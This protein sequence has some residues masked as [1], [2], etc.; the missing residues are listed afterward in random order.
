MPPKT[1]NSLARGLMILESSSHGSFRMSLAE[2]SRV[3]H[4]PKASAYRLLKTLT[5]LNYLKYDERHKEYYLGPKVLSLGFSVVQSLE[6]QEIIR[7]YLQSLSR[8]CAKTVNF[9]VLD[10]TEMVY[11]ERIRAP[12]AREF[13]ISIGSRIPIYSTAVGRIVMAHME[14]GKLKDILGRLDSGPDSAPFIADRPAL[15]RRLESIRLRGY[16][17]ADEEYLQGAGA[18]AA[19][20]FDSEG[21][22]GGINLVVARPMVTMDELD[23]E[24]APK[25]VRAA[26]EISHA[27]GYP[28]ENR[29]TSQLRVAP[30]RR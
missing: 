22:I 9:A 3:T 7:P 4:T 27:L 1:V 28:S 19:P 20:V 8:A 15:F 26:R 21:I 14:A 5:E 24:Y 11:I 10:D 12:D 29:V 2:I 17:R 18:V 25:L 13:T 23:K 30:E 6:I 16:A